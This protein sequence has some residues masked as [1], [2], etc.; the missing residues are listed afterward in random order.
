MRFNTCINPHNLNKVRV[1]NTFITPKRSQ[2]TPILGNHRPILCHSGLA[3]PEDDINGVVQWDRLPSHSRA[4]WRLILLFLLANRFSPH[5][6]AALGF[7]IHQ[8]KDPWVVSPFWWCEHTCCV[9][10]SFL[11]NKYLGREILGLRLP[12]VLLD[13]DLPACLQERP[14]RRCW[15]STRRKNIR[16]SQSLHILTSPWNCQIFY[17]YFIPFCSENMPCMIS[18]RLNWPRLVLRSQCHLFWWLFRA[19]LKMALPLLILVEGLHK[20][21]ADP[22]G[23]GGS[24]DFQVLLVFWPPDEGVLEAT[25]VV[26]KWST[27]PSNPIGV[28]LLY[29]EALFF[30]TVISSW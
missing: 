17:F 13:K 20:R 26:A 22:H 7:L 27:S 25:N 5:G 8:L 10:F 28:C 18:I 4:P 30:R 24:S 15:M 23:W 16:G 14:R 12:Y 3:F 29:F 9:W 21:H 1:E 2:S 19:C 11:S 6:Y